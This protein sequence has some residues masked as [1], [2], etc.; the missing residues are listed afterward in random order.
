MHV[1]LLGGHGKVALYL[2]P[3]LLNRSWSVT[4][5]VRNPDH[6]SEILDLGKGRKGKLSVLISSLESVK[7]ATDA[8]KIL[9]A[10]KPDYVVWSAGAGGKGGPARTIAIDQEA[11]KHFIEASFA[12][13]SVSKF[14]MVSWLGSRRKQPSWMTDDAWASV[15][16]AKNEILPTYAAAKLEADEYMTALAAKRKQEDPRPFQAIDLRPGGLKDDPATRKV[17]LGITGQAKGT[18]T[19]EDVAIVADQLLARADVEGWIDLVNGNVD[20]EEAVEKVAAEKIDAA[21]EEDVDEMVKRF[22]P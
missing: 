1:L 4:S 22:F 14:L 19:R 18:V 11:A 20:V 10:T 12:Y 5:I 6:E 7:S 3:L 17:E 15:M 13:P 9:D 16:V 21:A 2:T 8:K